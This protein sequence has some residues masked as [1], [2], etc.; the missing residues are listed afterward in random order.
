MGPPRRSKLRAALLLPREGREGGVDAVGGEG[1]EHHVG[2]LPH[3]RAVIDA[4]GARHHHEAYELARRGHISRQHPPAVAVVEP[5]GGQDRRVLQRLLRLVRSEALAAG[6]VPGAVDVKEH[7]HRGLLRR[8]VVGD[9]DGRPHAP[10]GVVDAKGARSK[11]EV[12]EPRGDREAAHVGARDDL[13]VAQS[14]G[15][16]RRGRAGHRHPGRGGVAEPTH[17]VAHHAPVGDVLPG[18]ARRGEG[19]REGPGLSRRDRDAAAEAYAGVGGEEGVA[20]V[21]GA[22]G[23]AP[24]EAP[25]GRAAVAHAHGALGARGAAQRRGEDHLDDLGVVDPE[26]DHVGRDGVDDDHVGRDDIAWRRRVHAVHRGRVARGGHVARS[27]DPEV[28]ARDHVD[29]RPVE[30]RRGHHPGLTRPDAQHER[31]ERP[32]DRMNSHAL[33]STAIPRGRGQGGPPEAPSPPQWTPRTGATPR[34]VAAPGRPTARRQGSARFGAPRVARPRH[35][36][37]TPVAARSAPSAKGR[38]ERA[39]VVVRRGHR[40]AVLAHRPRRAVRRAALAPGEAHDTGRARVGVGALGGPSLP[41]EARATRGVGHEPLAHGLPQGVA[42]LLHQRDVAHAA[43]G[44]HGRAL[45]GRDG[46][47]RLRLVRAREG[48]AVEARRARQLR[49]HVEGVV[50]QEG[51]DHQHARGERPEAQDRVPRLRALL[52]LLALVL[53]LHRGQQSQSRFGYLTLSTRR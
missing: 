47:Q 41:L 12:G 33:T 18:C 25:G 50:G 6:A 4:G 22:E 30:R 39:R 2:S 21:D 5:V 7:P 27:I 35:R 1:H 53:V 43:P 10:A 46:E 14:K 52:L 20:V 9:G 26:V 38:R 3:G 42:L 34:S 49:R 36:A 51:H 28:G 44:P 16:G 48:I 13:H 37:R 45:G 29:L 32:A 11:P 40:E 24:G 31:R 23:V 15:H 17:A 8:A 19:D